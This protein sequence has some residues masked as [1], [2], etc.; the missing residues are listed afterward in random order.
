MKS[1]QLVAYTND[2]SINALS[3]PE[4]RV[5]FLDLEFAAKEAEL[6]INEAKIRFR[7]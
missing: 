1:T 6:R 5:T 2:I 4:T 3:V 7:I